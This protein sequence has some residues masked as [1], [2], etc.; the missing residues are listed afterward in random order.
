M[1]FLVGLLLFSSKLL[2]INLNDINQIESEIKDL[3]SQPG[4]GL[5]YIQN[6]VI[7]L[8]NVETNLNKE[9]VLNNEK[10]SYL[11]FIL[12]NKLALLRHVNE[13]RLYGDL[14]Q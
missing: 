4:Y 10:I 9:R 1:F 6:L 7:Q 13:S 8:N 12:K 14:N 2:A 5:S 3:R 11:D